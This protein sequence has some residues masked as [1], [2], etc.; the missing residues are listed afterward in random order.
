MSS[1]TLPVHL[2]MILDG[3]GATKT[4]DG[5]AVAAA[6]P[7]MREQ[8]ALVN[9]LHAPIQLRF[10]DHRV[11]LAIQNLA[12]QIIAGELESHPITEPRG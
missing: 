12:K 9:T 8:L 3:W 7:N 2:L 6:V 1:D 4:L 10:P 11:N 5:N